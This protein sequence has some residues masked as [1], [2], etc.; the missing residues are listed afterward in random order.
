MFILTPNADSTGVL[1]VFLAS[2]KGGRI[3]LV[4]GGGFRLHGSETVQTLGE[5]GAL[6]RASHSDMRLTATVG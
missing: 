6:G 1:M 3:L 4:L 2:G 5:K